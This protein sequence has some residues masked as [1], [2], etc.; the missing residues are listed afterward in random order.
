M[1]ITIED[2]AE[3]LMAANKLLITAHVNPDGDAIGST[4]ALAALLR[5]KGK[6]AV[7]MLDD[8]LP[9]NLSFLPGYD[10]IVRPE[11]G[12]KADAEMLVILDTSLD[13]I[14][15][16]AK[17]A[18]GL[19]VLNIDHHISNDGKADFLYNDNR[20]ATAEIIFELV[21]RLGG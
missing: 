10:A 7:V 4:L 18:E 1:K 8:K 15:K 13:R 19:P 3:K 12:E 2:V 20:A 9:K 5:G 6:T 17:A 21:E 14:G 11:E 16:V